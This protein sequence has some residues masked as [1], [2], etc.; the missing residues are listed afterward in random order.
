[1]GTMP[2]IDLAHADAP[3]P[4][5]H[6]DHRTTRDPGEIL[7]FRFHQEMTQLADLLGRACT[8]TNVTQLKC[9][10]LTSRRTYK[11]TLWIRQDG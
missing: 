10:V 3:F 11:Y 5:A 8:C 4:S 1:M 6:P 9:A 2:S 7:C